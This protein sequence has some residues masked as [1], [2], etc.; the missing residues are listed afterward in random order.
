MKHFLVIFFLFQLN[1][2][3]GQI[4]CN[5][6][7]NK[8]ITKNDS[9]IFIERHIHKVSI[10][11]ILM[12]D[13]LKEKQA[14]YFIITIKSNLLNIKTYFSISCNEIIK[15]TIKKDT[16]VQIVKMLDIKGDQN[17]YYC[18]LTHLFDKSGVIYKTIC[19]YYPDKLFI[20]DTNEIIYHYDKKLLVKAEYYN[21]FNGQKRLF[22]KLIYKYSPQLT[23]DL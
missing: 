23:E 12:K 17:N 3:L 20:P 8:P 5:I 1:Y 16:I 6:W 18:I 21:V 15:Q 4:P 10:T 2:L 22:E 9:L 7:Q 11:D 13:S 19:K 14:G